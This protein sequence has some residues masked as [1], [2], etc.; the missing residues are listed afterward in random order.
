MQSVGRVDT[1]K[2]G[3]DFLSLATDLFGVQVVVFAGTAVLGTLKLLTTRRVIILS[4]AKS[5][6]YLF[7]Q[8]YSEG[9]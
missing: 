4:F 6:Q 9:T 3:Y 5:D 1:H 2:V 7:L 8:F